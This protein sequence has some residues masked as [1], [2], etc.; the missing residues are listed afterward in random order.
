LTIEPRLVTTEGEWLSPAA[1]AQIEAIFH[2]T[3]RETYGASECLVI[4]SECGH[5]WCHVN[6]DWAVLE[7]V[8]RAYRPIPAGCV[9]H[10]VLLTNLANRVQPIIRYDLGDSVLVR[11]DPCPCGSPFPAIRVEG[12]RDDIISIPAADGGMVPVP[13]LVLASVAEETPGVSRFQIVQVDPRTLR[14]RLETEVGADRDRIWK[15]LHSRLY[16]YLVAQ[17]VPSVKVEL[18]L[19]EP[20]RD[21]LSGKFR[22]VVVQCQAAAC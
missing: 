1:R 7:P 22:Q 3:V 5:G 15:E 13:P 9:S 20:Q 10:T 19:E 6:S 8:D 18:V 4:A 11:P 12:R 16:G 14:V 17:E 21:P 2:C